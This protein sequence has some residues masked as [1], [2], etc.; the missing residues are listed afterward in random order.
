MKFEFFV[1]FRFQQI[2]GVH[3]FQAYSEQIKVGT[4]FIV[5]QIGQ[6]KVLS[7]SFKFKLKGLIEAGLAGNVADICRIYTKRMQ[8]EYK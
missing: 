6:I 1:V 3:T 7:L 8:I 5:G 2:V 4:S